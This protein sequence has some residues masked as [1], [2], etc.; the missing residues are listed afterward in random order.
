MINLRFTNI[1]ILSI[2]ICYP[3]NSKTL[4]ISIDDASLPNGFY[5]SIDE[6]VNKILKALEVTQTNEAIIYAITKTL[7]SKDALNRLKKYKKS[8]H[9]IGNH[10]HS[11]LYASKVNPEAYIEDITKAH[12]YLKENN[13]L[14]LYFR[15]PYLDRGEKHYKSKKIREYLK[16]I[17]YKDAYVTIATKDWLINSLFQK[18]L[19]NFNTIDIYK[20]KDLYIKSIMADIQHAHQYSLN[21]FKKEIHHTLLLHE[22]D[23]TALFLEDLILKI[24]SKGWR[25]HKASD[26]YAD[27]NVIANFHNSINHYE[28]TCIST[29]TTIC[30]KDRDNI[31]DIVKTFKNSNIVLNKIDFSPNFFL[32]KLINFI[33]EKF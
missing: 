16:S 22:N 32:K 27:K 14:S 8:G 30:L 20:L 15:Y 3:V 29:K 26:S 11:H 17:N 24:K 9:L 12:E 2:L 31:E 10:T 1:L 23:I 33:R 19:A 13:L 18:E 21:V 6:R 5:F 28:S 7:Q 25:I 4:S